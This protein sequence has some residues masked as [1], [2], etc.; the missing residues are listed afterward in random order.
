MRVYRGRSLWPERVRRNLPGA[1]ENLGQQ[2]HRH[3]A[4]QTVAF[5]GN[6]EQLVDPRCLQLG[7]GVIELQRV[8]PPGK[9]GIAPIRQNLGSVVGIDPQVIL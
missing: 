8:R 7:V 1:L 5:A 3:V 9:I 6:G 4:A 2:Q